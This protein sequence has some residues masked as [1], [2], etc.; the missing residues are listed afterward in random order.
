M[1]RRL[2]LSALLALAAPF[3]QAESVDAVV[4]WSK[5]SALSVPVSGIVDRVEVNVGDRVNAGQLLLALEATPFKAAVTAAR[6]ELTRRQVALQEAERDARQADE[7]YERTVLSTVELENAKHKL[8]RAQADVKAAKALLAQAEYQL[9]ASALRAPFDGVV[10]GRF[11][12]PG[13]AV[14]SGVEA[15]TLL[16]FAASG[17]YLAVG[18][19]PVDRAAGLKPQEKVQVRVGDQ[20]YEGRVKAVGL[21]PLSGKTPLAYELQVTFQTR[22]VLRAGQAAVVELP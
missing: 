7:L 9:R 17:E 16:S 4:Q 21:E 5:K 20:R 8:T 12:Q 11:A 14:V 3:V 18:A 6:A 13:E 19:I 1:M 10:L 2:V 15:R 22:A